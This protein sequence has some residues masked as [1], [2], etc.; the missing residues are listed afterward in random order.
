MA[1]VLVLCALALFSRVFGATSADASAGALVFWSNGAGTGVT[2]NTKALDVAGLSAYLSSRA[3]T[4]EAMVLF[5]SSDGRA[6]LL[7]SSVRG[8]IEKAQESTAF[9]SVYITGE[10]SKAFSSAGT[11]LEKVQKVASLGALLQILDKDGGAVL[12]NGKTELFDVVLSGHEGESAEMAKL[13]AKVGTS[14][15]VFAAVRESS[16]AAPAS[17]LRYSRVLAASSNLVDGIYYKPEGGE[18]AIYYA[19]T[20][21]YLTPDI[22]TG[23]LSGIFFLFAVFIGFSCMNQIQGPSSFTHK[24]QMPAIGKEA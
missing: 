1:K 4:S 9:P 18:Y 11:G 13:H 15:I 2:H 24:E 14:Q 21:L 12:K 6:S 7:H 23:L 16:V 22:F 19:D 8:S 5:S 3:P 20:Y 10:A 17:E